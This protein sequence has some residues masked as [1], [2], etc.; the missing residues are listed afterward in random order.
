MQRIDFADL[1]VFLTVLRCRSF[2]LAA[3]ELGLSS[4][5]VSHAVRRLETRLGARLLN[6]TSRAVS[7]T[8]LG[9]DLAERLAGGFD[10]I[11]SAL[12]TINAPGRGRFGELRINVFADAAHL[13]IT[14]ALQAFSERCADVKLTIVIEDRPVDITAE[15]FDAGV[16]Y[17]HLVPEDMIAV[18]LSGDQQWIIAAS[19]D[20]LER[21]GTPYTFSDLAQHN[22]LQLL[23]G[24]NASF[25]WEFGKAENTVT[26]N[27]PGLISIKDT[28][29]TISAARAGLGLGYFLE[30]RIEEELTQ[31]TLV[32]VLG[33]FA[34]YGAP[35]HMYYSSR[36]H[37]HPALRELV[38]I[39]RQQ[40]GLQSLPEL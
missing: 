21:R 17:G 8:A 6:R 15:G 16:R 22:C 29:T 2:K 20:Y 28:A 24:N 5:A 11:S 33:D 32:K 34:A 40:N 13:L 35:F 1:Q 14:P 3:I 7:S 26:M 23:L 10:A 25:R 9:M 19:P 18:P 12:E 4:S 30:S 31:G 27:V 37:G 38:N 36:R 39:I